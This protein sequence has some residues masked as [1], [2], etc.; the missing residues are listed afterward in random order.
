MA[1]GVRF[2]RKRKLSGYQRAEA[3]KRRAAAELDGDCREL[4]RARIM[5]SRLEP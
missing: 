5:I 3:I 4:G 2:G 1:K